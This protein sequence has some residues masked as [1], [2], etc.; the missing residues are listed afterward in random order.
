MAE[1]SGWKRL[2]NLYRR[3]DGSAPMV[4][5]LELPGEIAVDLEPGI[6]HDLT[7]GV[8]LRTEE[9]YYLIAFDELDGFVLQ[10]GGRIMDAEIRAGKNLLRSSLEVRFGD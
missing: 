8:A 2:L 1:L 9:R 10:E 7:L 3:P 5:E 4:L 6:A